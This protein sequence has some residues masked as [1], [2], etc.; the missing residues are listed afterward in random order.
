MKTVVPASI[1]PPMIIL[2]SFVT[3]FILNHA[4]LG[5]SYMSTPEITSLVVVNLF[6]SPSP[7]PSYPAPRSLHRHRD[8]IDS[9][10]N[11]HR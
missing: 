10:M 6:T 1:S 11:E 8:V 9:V 3:T 7:P 2:L 5:L 4:A